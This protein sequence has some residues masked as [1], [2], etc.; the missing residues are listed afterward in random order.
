MIPLNSIKRYWIAYFIIASVFVAGCSSKTGECQGCT[1]PTFVPNV[2]LKLVDQATKQDLFFGPGAKYNT[3]MLRI[4]HIEHG[5]VDSVPAELKIDTASHLLNF[6]LLYQNDV[7]TIAIQVGT[8]KPQVL[9][10]GTGILNSCCTKVIVTTAT[11]NG[12]LIF[13]APDDPKKQAKMANQVTV[14]F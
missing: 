1:D 9:Y 2:S 5:R 12:A 3:A 13:K 6:K 7:D 10:L 14:A 11:F 4:R 8:Q